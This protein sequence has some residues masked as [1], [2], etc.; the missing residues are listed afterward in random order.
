MPFRPA[1]RL[2]KPAVPMQPVVDPAA[3]R[4][5]DLAATDDWI[6]ELTAAEIDEVRAAVD[7]VE[8][9]GLDILDIGRDDFPLPRFDAMLAMLYDELKEGRGFVL[10]RGLPADDLTT[11]QKAAAFWG[12]GLRFGRALSQNNKGHMLGHVKDFGGDYADPNVRGYQTAAEMTYHSDQCDYVALL[13]VHPSKSGG[14]SRITSS[15][16]IYNDMLAARPDLAREL[17]AEFH[18][19]RHGEIPPGEKPWYKLPIFSFHEGYF[20]GR[21]AGVHTLKAEGLPGVPPFT[22]AQREA[23]ALFQETARRLRFEMDFRPG[24]IQILHSHLTVHTR[25]A[26]EDWPE[27]ERK[28]HLMRLWLCDDRNGRPLVPGFRENLQGVTVAGMKP[29]APINSF[30]PA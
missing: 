13:C 12:I 28:R 11:A 2:R 17:T 15:V 20:S 10:I 29:T 8:R 23:I 4:A 5:E 9:R 26:F 16:S 22:D 24:D 19:T 18:Q 27:P 7:G 21:G 14:E 25:S 6:Y 1:P 3:W 30:E